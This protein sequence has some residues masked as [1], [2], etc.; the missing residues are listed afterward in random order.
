ML[1][2]VV[3]DNSGTL[4][5]RYRVVKD[6]HTGVELFDVNSL[7]LIDSFNDAALVV[8]QINPDKCLKKVS[9]DMTAYDFIQAK[10]IN[11]DISYSHRD[12]SKEEVLDILSEDKCCV[13]DIQ[14]SVDGVD[15]KCN[16]IDLC[17]GSALI[18]DMGAR[19][20]VYTITSA[21]V[22][23]PSVVDTVSRILSAGWDIYI[24]SGDRTSSLKHLSELIG[25]NPDNAFGTVNTM[26]KAK[27]IQDLQERYDCVVMV[28]NGPNDLLAFNQA[29]ISILTVEQKED[30]PESLVLSA[31]KVIN[32]FS[33]LLDLD[34]FF[35]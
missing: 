13:A 4:S 5:E 8:L 24:A 25:I 35:K 29:D 23:F 1:G 27:I 14:D 22:L 30:L 32:R 9:Q 10:N 12:I 21:G 20:V 17:I 19:R 33:D 15:S 34:I 31:D 11:F 2:A 3:F 18:L 28:G 7:A 6:V 26:G 16:N